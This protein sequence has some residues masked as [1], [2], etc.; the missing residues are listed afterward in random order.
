MVSIQITDIREI[1]YDEYDDVIENN[2]I[3]IQ[4]IIRDIINNNITT[5]EINYQITDVAVN[6]LTSALLKNTSLVHI[7]F[8]VYQRYDKQ[9]F[10]ALTNKKLTY[11]SILININ[12]DWADALADF[13]CTNTDLITLKLSENN[14][15]TS[16]S[17][18][19]ADLLSTNTISLANLYLDKTSINDTSVIMLAE[20]LKTNTSLEVLDLSNNDIGLDGSLALANALLLNNSLTTLNLDFVTNVDDEGGKAF[21]KVLLTNTSLTNIRFYYTRI[22]YEGS[23]ALANALL[24]NTSLTSIKLNYIEPVTYEFIYRAIQR[25]IE[26]PKHKDSLATFNNVSHL[27]VE[28]NS[29]VDSFV[30]H[31]SS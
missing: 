29:I 9:I 27:P 16:C 3:D 8:N 25:N 14:I 18:V 30:L 21:A 11:L 4:E 31:L 19:L 7:N 13:L 6:E 12:D 2:M 15:S 24:K 10:M 28:L 17:K 5:L 23:K 20:A 26:F 22:G 1:M